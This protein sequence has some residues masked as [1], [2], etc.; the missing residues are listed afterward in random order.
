VRIHLV[1]NPASGGGTDIDDLRRRLKEAG[2]RLVEGV[3]KAERIVVSGGDGMI[4][5]AAEMAA[6]RGIPL[7]VIPSGTANDFAN[8]NKL[9]CDL[10]DAV[11]LAATGQSSCE[12]ELGRMDGRPFVN[13]ASAGLS[14]A[15]A[16]RATPLKRVLGPVAYPVGG[17]LAGVLDASLECTVEGHFSGRAWQLIVAC[18]GAFGG[19]VELDA[20][21][22]HDRQ[23]DLL[24][25]RDRGRL[26]L[27]GH[28]LAMRRGSLAEQDGV[29]HVRADAFTV[30]LAPSAALNV[31]GELVDEHE[32][33]LSFTVDERTFALVCP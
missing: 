7:A 12:H 21:D 14:P 16:R 31:D 5:P 1:A 9:P 18:T 3:D 19:G 11:E 29:L 26:A 2:A 10:E 8:A 28:A 30:T 32:G 27:P 17:V 6:E 15:A 13:V 23:L 33:T 25:L 4:G 20:T 24:V 22:Q